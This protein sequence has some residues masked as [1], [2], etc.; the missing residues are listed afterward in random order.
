[1]AN[2]LETMAPRT[3]MV[4]APGAF[5]GGNSIASLKVL[6]GSNRIP[7]RGLT[8]APANSARTGSARAAVSGALD[9][10]AVGMRLKPLSFATKLLSSS[11]LFLST[12]HACRKALTAG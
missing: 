8:K 3:L 9:D 10:V 6:G 11:G 12:Y 4:L 5:A 7:T 2:S 1:M